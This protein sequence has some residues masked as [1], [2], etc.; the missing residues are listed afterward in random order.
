[1]T[2][3]M[4]SM[5]RRRWLLECY[6]FNALLILLTLILHD[7]FSMVFGITVNPLD[8]LVASFDFDEYGGS[9]DGDR[10]NEFASEVHDSNK[11][12]Q[13][14]SGYNNFAGSSEISGTGG[15]YVFGP[16]SSA[17]VK[18]PIS[19]NQSDTFSEF[20]KMFSIPLHHSVFE[21][22]NFFNNRISIKSRYVTKPFKPS[23]LSPIVLRQKIVRLP[24][25]QSL[26]SPL[27]AITDGIKDRLKAIYPGTLWCG[28]GNQARNQN[29]IGLF[30]NTD[31]CCKQH[32]ECPAFIKSGSEFK[33]LR[34][35]GLFTRSHCDCD[36]KFYN[37]LKRTDS[38]ISNK[39]GY[40][41]FNILRPQCFR[42]EFRVVGCKKWVNKKCIVYMV[43]DRQPGV[44]Q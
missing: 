9:D 24:P 25:P 38:L 37:C 36:L 6:K 26:S 29:E 22:P 10:S 21:V 44:W 17:I 43:D 33:G 23:N 28:D 30:R 18:Q 8:S 19:E 2:Q 3:M 4:Q 14:P 13:F 42:K 41:Y 1:M 34:N 5:R 39:I 20:L 15:A 7:R 31:I 32:D 12:D 16:A 40:T 27:T 11:I 35:T